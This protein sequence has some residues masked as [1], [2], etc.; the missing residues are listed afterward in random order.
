MIGRTLDSFRIVASLGRGGMGEVWKAEQVTLGNRA[1]ALKLLRG[2]Q[3]VAP[4]ALERL[5]REGAMLARLKH[6]GI[7][8]IYQ[9][10][11]ADG[12]DYVAMEFVEGTTLAARLATGPLTPDEAR[13]VVI[14]VADAL[15]S[16][17]ESGVLHRDLTP[18]NVML[19]PSGRVVLLDFGLALALEQSRL[20]SDGAI[21]GTANY[22]APEVLNRFEP[23]ARSD[24]YSLGVVLYESLA[25]T[26]PFS[27]ERRE[28]VLRAAMLDTPP[29]PSRFRAGLSPAWD[30]LVLRAIAREPGLRYQSA[31]E[32]A[33]ELAAMDVVHHAPGAP[34]VRPDDST[35]ETPLVPISNAGSPRRLAVLPFTAPGGNAEASDLAAGFA[36]SLCAGL[37]RYAALRIVSPLATAPTAREGAMAVARE[38]GAYLVLGGTL[39][40]SGGRSR[41]AWTLMRGNDP[42]AS[43]GGVVEAAADAMFE[44]ED[45]VVR[46]LAV[47]LGVTAPSSGKVAGPSDPAS[48]EHYLQ[49]V[50]YLQRYDNEASIDGAIVLLEKLTR[51]TGATADVWS[52]LASAYRQKYRHTLE[53]TWLERSLQA[54]LQSQS[55]APDSPDALVA[56]AVSQL[57]LGRL[58]EAEAGLSKALALN[59]SH[60]RSLLAL[61]DVLLAQGRLGEAEAACRQAIA[62]RPGYWGAYNSLGGVHFRQGR[63]QEAIGAW[64]EVIRIT[65]DNQRGWNNLAAALY[66]TGDLD[67]AQK[68]YEQSLTVGPSAAAYVGLGT[69][70]FYADDMEGARTQ[71][72]HAVK[73]SPNSAL[74]WGNLGDACRYLVHAEEQARSAYEQAIRLARE[75]FDINPRD[76]GLLGMLASWQA[77]LG[78]F[79]DATA[80][81][82][83]TLDATPNHHQNVVLSVAI[84]ELAGERELAL[85]QLAQASR[86]GAS[87]FDIERSPSMAALRATVEYSKILGCHK[88]TTESGASVARN[89]QRPGGDT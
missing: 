88:V 2:D 57:G 81:I 59:P 47:A 44:L 79:G 1:V 4:T 15:A 89:I 42:S 39:Q 69:L 80:N 34:D 22:I 67:E 54:G 13:R 37:T 64:R 83:R 56:V 75:Q 36:Q 87:L 17:H 33:R 11:V 86:L 30:T 58:Q 16:A 18:N 3:P 66:R 29:P 74:V 19:E 55:L 48:H 78:H 50:G 70:R 53:R 5:R 76:W 85:R 68:A 40:Q 24:V 45:R 71:F 23:D 65:P 63:M 7:A 12:I 28:Q 26:T 82:R 35:L 60:T 31:R 10:G 49:A 21:L 27:G 73:L 25:G 20:T 46:D 38:F 9:A 77:R 72:E 6:P 62:V 52:S 51:D 8:Q 32:F 61:A 41:V 84:F 43:W 14:G